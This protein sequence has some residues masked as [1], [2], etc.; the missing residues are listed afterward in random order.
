M[1]SKPTFSRRSAMVRGATAAG[2]VAL[3]SS[4]LRGASQASPSAN[5]GAPVIKN[6]RI[7]QSM[8]HWCF[9]DHWDVERA[10]QVGKQLGLKSVEIVAPEFW[11]ILKKYGLICACAPSHGFKV[12]FNDPADWPHC[13]EILT[14]Q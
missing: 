12:G 7:N 10:A 13:K 9:K 11:P 6:G 8:V 1:E 5:P 2:A 4:V 14:K 3:A